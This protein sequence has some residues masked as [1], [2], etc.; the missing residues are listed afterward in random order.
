MWS[1]PIFRQFLTYDPFP[2]DQMVIGVRQ[3]HH[4]HLNQQLFVGESPLFVEWTL[5]NFLMTKSYFWAICFLE[6][7]EATTRRFR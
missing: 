6:V 7:K 2:K 3:S 5:S 4:N 1:F